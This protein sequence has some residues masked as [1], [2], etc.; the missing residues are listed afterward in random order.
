M[1]RL[2]DFQEQHENE[3]TRTSHPLPGAVTSPA[4]MGSMNEPGAP[5]GPR[6]VLKRLAW[7]SAIALGA[8]LLVSVGAPLTST[9][10]PSETQTSCTVTKHP[11]EGRGRR[12]GSFFPRVYTDCG[13]FRSAK[14]AT[15]TADPEQTTAL[16]PG[17]NYDLTVRGAELP[18][19]TS[20]EIVS[21]TV[22][23]N[24][25]FEPREFIKPLDS[26]TDD[27][28]FNEM[29]R[30]I[31]NRPE[32]RALNEKLAKLKAEFSPETLRAFDYEQPAYSPECDVT[33]HVMTSKGLQIMDATRATEALTPPPGMAP[34]TPLLPCEG[35]ECDPPVR[36]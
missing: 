36:H 8:G 24:Q 3:E 23:P 16:I 7:G 20:R 10:F 34:R 31:Q 1:R 5:R 35:F 4:R 14:Q 27:E 32:N 12:G 25:S 33:R 15:C 19:T 26:N 6:K 22:S 9:L 18:F 13:V 21:V 30:D 2:R 28:R 17:F 29:V 11:F